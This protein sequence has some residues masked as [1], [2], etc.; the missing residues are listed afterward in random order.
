MR[1]EAG[2]RHLLG[3]RRF[4]SRGRDQDTADTIYLKLGAA[5]QGRSRSMPKIFAP[6]LQV[7]GTD[8]ALIGNPKGG[9]KC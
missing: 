3:E 4:R 2:A 9:A 5:D 1:V 6:F 8:R 7:L